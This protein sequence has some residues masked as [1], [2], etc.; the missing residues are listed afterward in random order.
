MQD[1]TTWAFRKNSPYTDLFSQELNRLK[2]KGVVRRVIG[3]HIDKVQRPLGQFYE[4]IS[5]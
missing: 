4:S 1:S 5:A 2:E 3:Q